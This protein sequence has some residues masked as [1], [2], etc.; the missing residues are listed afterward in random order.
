MKIASHL[1]SLFFAIVLLPV[2]LSA[3][4]ANLPD[5]RMAFTSLAA[6]WEFVLDLPG[7]KITGTKTSKDGL[8]RYFMLTN[9]KTY[10]NA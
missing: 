9:E 8:S 2:C 3:Q 6:P 4:S 1:V 7:F 5:G 10:V